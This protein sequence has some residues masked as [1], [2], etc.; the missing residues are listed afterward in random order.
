LIIYKAKEDEFKSKFGDDSVRKGSFEYY[1]TD[2]G[3]GVRKDVI[4]ST[5]DIIK[6]SE[7]EVINLDHREE[8]QLLDTI[9][10]EYRPQ[11]KVPKVKRYWDYVDEEKRTRVIMYLVYALPVIFLVLLAVVFLRIGG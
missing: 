10:T 2:R 11:I 8:L 1:I 4:C 7:G 6:E 5:I 3:F 9:S